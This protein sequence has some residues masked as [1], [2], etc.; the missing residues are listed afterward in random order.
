MKRFI[1]VGFLLTLAFVSIADIGFSQ[2][3]DKFFAT[4]GVKSL[5]EMAHPSNYYWE[6]LYDIKPGYVDMSITSIDNITEG[7]VY[8]DLR[9]MRSA[10]DTHFGDIIVVRDTDPWANPFEAFKLQ[11]Q[12][13][14]LTYKTLLGEA[15]FNKML[16]SFQETFHTD[17]TKWTAKQWAL[18]VINLDYYAFAFTGK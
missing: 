13:A 7:K 3:L 11:I 15:E 4:R 18:V 9:L 6:G 2:T 10:G 5:S 12:V 8:T 16:A 14:L 1:T 17:M